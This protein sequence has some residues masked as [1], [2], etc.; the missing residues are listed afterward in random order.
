[1][2]DIPSSIKKISLFAEQK[3]LSRAL[4]STGYFWQVSG[5]LFAGETLWQGRN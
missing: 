2:W 1:M 3:E 4:N 5:G